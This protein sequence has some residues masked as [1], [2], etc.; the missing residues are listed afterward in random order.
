MANRDRLTKTLIDLIRR[1]AIYGT[2]VCVALDE[3]EAATP[4]WWSKK[5]GSEY[6]ACLWGVMAVLSAWSKRE[7]S[8]RLIAYFFESGQKRHR[9]TSRQ[10]DAIALNPALKKELRYASHLFVEKGLEI[11]RP[12][13]AA[14]FLAWHL[15]KLL[16]SKPE[17]REHFF[18]TGRFPHASKLRKDFF[19]LIDGMEDRYWLEPITGERLDAFFATKKPPPSTATT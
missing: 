6:D 13:E 9:E 7:G 3:F 5:H 15:N 4:D 19:A 14:D 2:A 17:V 16:G 10:L 8:D 11:S 18:R 1:C 12:C